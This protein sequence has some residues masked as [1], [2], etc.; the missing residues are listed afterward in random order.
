MKFFIK[1][2]L[3]SSLAIVSICTSKMYNKSTNLSNTSITNKLKEKLKLTISTQ[4]QKN[5]EKS[6]QIEDKLL[7]TESKLTDLQNKINNQNSKLK[8]EDDLYL[9]EKSVFDEF[10]STVKSI[11]EQFKNFFNAE[12]TTK[13]KSNLNQMKDLQNKHKQ[14]IND[15][16]NISDK[17]GNTATDIKKKILKEN[18]NE[19]VNEKDEGIHDLDKLTI[20]LSEKSKLENQITSQI[21]G[22]IKQNNIEENKALPLKNNL[23]HVLTTGFN[24]LTQNLE[25]EKLLIKNTKQNNKTLL[26]KTQQINDQVIAFSNILEK[27]KNQGIAANL[28]T[29]KNELLGIRKLNKEHNSYKK[30]ILESIKNNK[31]LTKSEIHNLSYE[32]LKYKQL[33]KKEID[34]IKLLNEQNKIINVYADKLDSNIKLNELEQKLNEF[35]GIPV[36]DNKIAITI[37]ENNDYYSVLKLANNQTEN[38]VNNIE[39]A[40][41]KV[42]NNYKGIKIEL[43]S[44]SDKEK[45][46]ESELSNK[47][48]LL[49]E[50]EDMVKIKDNEIKL[51]EK[52]LKSISNL[53]EKE[54]SNSEDFSLKIKTFKNEIEEKSREIELGKTKLAKEQ[55]EIRKN[56]KIINRLKSQIKTEENEIL[57]EKKI[58]E[59]D[60]IENQKSIDKIKELQSQLEKMNQVNN[61]LI[62]VNKNEKS[63][64][65]NLI[66]LETP[67]TALSSNEIRKNPIT[68]NPIKKFKRN[69]NSI[70]SK[71]KNKK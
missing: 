56:T 54:K 58:I 65:M 30:L 60:N 69:K 38:F 1:I 2:I 46:I 3:I 8:K 64:I 22:L 41:N 32:F 31:K 26:D 67:S 68:P 45:K 33:K 43:D 18:E 44:V 27:E 28:E 16:N 5:K 40:I 34:K 15:K 39:S 4:I 19:A 20:E 62:Q 66:N 12:P 6:K 63:T 11:E 42:E 59:K 71:K 7:L 47:Q 10:S 35:V 70:L 61:S 48:N 57:K 52:D 53:L 29:F 55:Q 23:F 25:K 13:I 14:L 17:I 51:K 50:Y 21:K 37:P 24:F 36:K 9:Q 49:Q